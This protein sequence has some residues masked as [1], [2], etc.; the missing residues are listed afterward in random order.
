MILTLS[1][2]HLQNEDELQVDGVDG[3]VWGNGQ[4]HV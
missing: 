2:T 4:D 3:K 1:P